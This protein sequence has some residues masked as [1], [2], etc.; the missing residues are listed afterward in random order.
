MM[1]MVHVKYPSVLLFTHAGMSLFELMAE[2]EWCSDELACAFKFSALHSTAPKKDSS[3]EVNLV[4]EV[5]NVPNSFLHSSTMVGS[6]V[7]AAP[8]LYQPTPTV[9]VALGLSF[10]TLE[11]LHMCCTLMITSL[12]TSHIASL[13]AFRQ[14]ACVLLFLMD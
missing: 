8:S 5:V 12:H 14:K 9:S 4:A 1:I 11:R 3:S 10:G 6:K 7:L 13:S 2:P